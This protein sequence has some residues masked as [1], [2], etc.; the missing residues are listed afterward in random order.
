MIESIGPKFN[1]EI[2]TNQKGSDC[3]GKGSMCA[4]TRVLIRSIRTSWVHST[5]VFLE[6]FLDSVTTIYFPSLIHTDVPFT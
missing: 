5:V 6:N 2:S 1:R 3:V 4:F